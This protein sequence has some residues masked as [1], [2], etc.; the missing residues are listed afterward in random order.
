MASAAQ[1]NTV[2][3]RFEA[4]TMAGEVITPSFRSVRTRPNWPTS[5]WFG[6][7]AARFNELT[8]LE[9]GWDGYKGLPVKFSTAMFAA[10]LL[11]RVA[12]DRVPAPSLIPGADGSLQIEWHLKGYDI[13]IDIRDAF[14]LT[15]VRIDHK[16]ELEEEVDLQDD[17]ALIASW[18]ADLVEERDA[19]AAA[20]SR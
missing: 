15:A 8:S 20:G 13:E 3:Q 4:P 6:S 1:A 10:Q 17:F 2:F 16:N 11:E 5:R 19:I 9:R 12:N 14:D 7:L 18:V